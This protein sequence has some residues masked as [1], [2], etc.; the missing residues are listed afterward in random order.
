MQENSNVWT[1]EQK[2][3]V[4]DLDAEFE[5]AVAETGIERNSKD[6]A[7]LWRSGGFAKRMAEIFG[8]EYVKYDG[9]GTIGAGNLADLKRWVQ[10][11]HLPQSAKDI[12]NQKIA[13]LEK[14]SEVPAQPETDLSKDAEIA[15]MQVLE[16]RLK[17]LKKMVAKK[18]IATL[19]TRIKIVQ[20][21][22]NNVAFGKDF[23]ASDDKGAVKEYKG[24][25]KV[26]EIEYTVRYEKEVDGEYD[27]FTKEFTDLKQALRFATDNY[28]SIEY[29]K[30]LN[31]TPIENGIVNVETGALMPYKKSKYDGGGKIN[32]GCNHPKA[33]KGAKIDSKLYTYNELL[34]KYPYQKYYVADLQIDSISSGGTRSYAVVHTKTGEKTKS[35]ADIYDKNHLYFQKWVRATETEKAKYKLVDNPYEKKA[36]KGA[37]IDLG[38]AKPGNF[39]LEEDEN[40]YKG[41]YFEGQEWNGWAI[42][43]FEYSEAK[44]LIQDQKGG[45]IYGP[46]KKIKEQGWWV[47][48]ETNAPADIHTYMGTKIQ[49]I[50]GEKEVYS[51]GGFEWTWSLVEKAAK[52]AKI[53]FGFQNGKKG[54]LVLHEFLGHGIIQT[55]NADN[56]TFDVLFFDPNRKEY[57]LKTINKN[58]SGIYHVKK[59]KGHDWTG[60]A[61]KPSSYFTPEMIKKYPTRDIREKAAN[62]TKIN[63][64]DLSYL[65]G[66]NIYDYALG[67]TEPSI[68]RI[69]KAHI[70]DK[71]F[72][73]RDVV[74]ATARGWEVRFPLEQLP[75]FL[76]FEEIKIK[77]DKDPSVIQLIK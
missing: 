22:L 14:A 35:G 7:N 42:P 43:Y 63:S 4:K 28:A 47:S 39:T 71:K 27:N 12:L 24:G 30:T 11:P 34:E 19:K 55:V 29:E 13:E 58:S 26:E 21:M 36:A 15:K 61:I 48:G 23:M 3:K 32:C 16:S 25:G 56:I 8:K 65:S 45:R 54:D 6:A 64:E 67:E 51:I 77:G 38:L 52:G 20:K 46:D 60:N 18:P 9:G 66:K 49:T 2:Q 70:T 57:I 40:S 5:I 72:D 74:I 62:G 53:P 73:K 10:N 1:A 31:N 76:N 59:D 75:N 37:K 41:Y 68:T 33:A 17:L 50:D 44:R 69:D